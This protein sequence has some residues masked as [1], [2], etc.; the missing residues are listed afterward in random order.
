MRKEVHSK[1]HSLNLTFF[2]AHLM[3]LI[4]SHTSAACL[5]RFI[6]SRSFTA[7]ACAGEV[8]LKEHDDFDKY[9]IEIR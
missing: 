5:T 8:S 9:A 4:L 6:R 2:I 3:H 7:I 1:P